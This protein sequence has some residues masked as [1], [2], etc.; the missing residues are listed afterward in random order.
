[1]KI[2]QSYKRLAAG[3]RCNTAEENRQRQSRGTKRAMETERIAIET[4]RLV[5][6]FS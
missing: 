3:E 6:S 5:D 1:M 2:T 4:F